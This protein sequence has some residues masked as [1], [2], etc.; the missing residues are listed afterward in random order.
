MLPVWFDMHSGPKI[1]REDIVHQEVMNEWIQIDQTTEAK[2]S[3][4][5]AFHM[6]Y[7]CYQRV[8]CVL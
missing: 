6:K 3:Y 1:T 4:Y 8:R 5:R 7:L 2:I